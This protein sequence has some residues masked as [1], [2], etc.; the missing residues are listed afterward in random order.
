V[1]PYVRADEHPKVTF[2][3]TAL[4]KDGWD[5]VE[6]HPT[7][8]AAQRF[9]TEVMSVE[10]IVSVKVE[11]VSPLGFIGLPCP[12]CHGTACHDDGCLTLAPEDR[13]PEPLA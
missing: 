12:Q 2:R 3:V 9:V 8:A 6:E 1:K 5:N 7:W 13:W 10:D 11:K 4:W